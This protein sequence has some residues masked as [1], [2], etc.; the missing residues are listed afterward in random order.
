MPISL[1][2][3]NQSNIIRNNKKNKEKE[4]TKK[5]KLLGKHEF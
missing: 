2:E 4:S 1:D 5:I 3:I